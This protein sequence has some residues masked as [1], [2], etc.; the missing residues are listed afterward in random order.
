MKKLYLLILT[1]V[2]FQA[3]TA[4]G[5]TN[6]FNPTDPDVVFTSTN[7]PPAPA[8]GPIAKWGHTQRMNWTTTSF[9]SY[10]YKGMVF[11]LKFPK[12]Y[13]HNT[14]DGKKY[15]ISLFFHG[16]GERGD[17]Y[18]NE[19]SMY[20]GG[21]EWRDNVDNNKFDGFVLYHQSENG[22]HSYYFQRLVELIDSL[23]KH[24]KVDIDRVFLH[25]L[26]SGGQGVFDFLAAYPK[27]ISHTAPLCAAQTE[28]VPDQIKYIHIPIWGFF[29]GKDTNPTLSNAEYVVGEFKNKGGNIKMTVYPEQGHG[30]WYSAWADPG[31][32][33]FMNAGHK[34]NPLVFFGRTE[35]C[36][37]DA[38]SV[39]MGLTSGFNAYEWQKDGVNIAGATS[40]QITVTQLGT[41]RV[42]FKRTATS[43][44]S[45]YSPTPV[46]VKYKA[47][48]QTPAIQITGLKSK[49]LPSPDGSTTTPLEIPGGYASYEW[50]RVS[51]NVVVSTQS[52]YNAAPGQYKAKV[53]EQ[54]GCS[55]EFSPVFT[56]I[57][58][59]GANA[60]DAAKNLVAIANSKT[61]IQLDWSDNPNAPNNE[62]G[63]EIY[64]STTAGGPYS[65]IMINPA[66][67]LSFLDQGLLSNN[68]YSYIVR[69]VNSNGAAVNS[70]E[71]T[72]ATNVDDSPPSAPSNLRFVGASPSSVSLQWDASIDDI[73]IS[74]YDIYI[75]GQKAYT[76]DKSPFTANNLTNRQTYNFTVRA[77]DL[78]GNLSALSN[79]VTATAKISGLSYKYYE[80]A[81]NALP[82]F[83]ALTPVKTGNSVNVDISVRNRSDNF[84][85]LWQGFIIIPASA[86]YTFETTSDDGSKLYIGPYNHTSTAL[87]NNDGLHGSQFRT[88]TIT[89]QAGVYPISITYFEQGGGEAM[90]VWWSSVAAGIPRQ[91]IPNSAFTETVS[92]PE[93]APIAPS[94]LQATTVS[95]DKIN[96]QWTD[97]SS[98][99]T[100]FEIVRS[101][102]AGG[103]FSTITTVGSNIQTFTDNTGIQAQTRYF[104]KVRAIGAYG[105]SVYSSNYLNASFKLNNDYTDFSGNGRTLSGSINPPSFSAA[106][107]QEG[108]HSLLFDGVNDYRDIG[109]GT[110]NFT[111]EL[112]TARTVSLWMKSELNTG[113]RLIFEL[114]GSDNGLALRLNGVNLEVGIA[115]NNSRSTISALFNSLAWKHVTVTY[116]ANA[117]FLYVDGVQVASKTNLTFTQV[118]ASSSSSRLATQ[119]GTNAFNANPTGFFKGYM[120]DLSYFTSALSP[121]DVE[122]LKNGTFVTSSAVTAN[123]P[124]IPVDPTSL[125]ASAASSNLNN[126]VWSDNSDNESGF[127]IY[128]SVNNNNN[129]RL[130]A[131]VPGS[132]GGSVNYADSSLFANVLYYYKVRAIGL[133][134]NSG[135]SN[136]SQ[137]KTSNG[138]PVLAPIASFTMKYGTQVNVSVY[139]ED[140]DGDPITLA[141]TNLPAFA[142]FTDNGNGT[143]SLVFSPAIAN[144]GNYPNIT[145]TATDANSGTSNSTFTVIVNNNNP[146][147]LNAIANSTIDEGSTAVINLSASDQDGNTGLT[148]SGAN[149]PAFV[150]LAGNANGT[151]QVTLNP[152][153]ASSG[154]YTVQITVQDPQ[155]GSATRP[156][157]ITVNDKNPNTR[158]LVNL[159]Y[160]STGP[161]PWNNM[162][163]SSIANLKNTDN[164]STTV[165]VQFSTPGWWQPW[166]LGATTGNNSGVYPD[167]V[168]RD[169]YYFGIYGGPE[170]VNATVSG[171]T[172]GKVYNFKFFASSTWTGFPDNGT[173]IYTIGS[174]SASLAVQNNTQNTANISGVMPDG[175][176]KIVFTMSK[177]PGTPLGYLNA[178][179]FET[180]FDDGSA[181]AAPKDLKATLLQGT[182]VKLTW[183][184]VAFNETRYNVY[185]STDSLGT[186]DLLNPAATNPNDSS[187]N[188]NT[189]GALTKYYYKVKAFNTNGDSEFSTIAGITTSNNNPQVSTIQDVVV[190]TQN[191][192]NVPFTATDNPGDVVIVTASLPSFATLQNVG[193]GNYNIVLAPSNGDI[194]VFNASVTATDSYGGTATDHFQI[195]VN[196][197]NTSSIFINFGP[198]GATAPLPW[199]NSL[200]YTFAGRVVPNLKDDAGNNS[201]VSLTY[202][203]GWSGSLDYGFNTGNNSG[204]Y[205]D[206]VL[207]SSLYEASVTAKRMQLSG[208]DPSKLYNIVALGSVNAG[209]DASSTYTVGL[210]SVVLNASFNSTK[211]VQ[212][213]GIS[214]DPGGKIILNITK[215]ASST[216]GYLNAIVIQSYD[217][218][219]SILS[220]KDLFVEPVHN[221]RTTLKLQW[222]DRSAT[223][224]SM[225]VW[226]STSLN[227]SYTL[228]ATL[229]AN[230]TSHT[231]VG[232]NVNTRYFYKISAVN[233]ATQSEFSNVGSATTPNTTVLINLTWRYPAG[234]PWNNTA[235]NPQLGDRFAN[236]FDDQNNNTGMALNLLG[237]FNGEFY[238][239]MN[240]GNNSGIFPDQVLIGSYWID[241]GQ[242]SPLKLDGLDQTKKYRVGFL[243]STDWTGELTSTLTINGKTVYLN[244][245]KN[246]SKVVYINDISPNGDGEILMSF[247]A[248]GTYGHLG[249][250]V[251]QSYTP[252]TDNGGAAPQTP[253]RVVQNVQVTQELNKNTA[254]D[255]SG[256]EK[257]QNLKAF[258]NP[259]EDK[260]NI[261]FDKVISAK[262]LTVEV[263]S[264]AG[265]ALYRNEY[266]V[267]AGLGIVTVKIPGNSLQPG[268]YLARISENGRL[269]REFKLVKIK[270]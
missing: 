17:L 122:A 130:L 80:G 270:K 159:V 137:S 72:T 60:P 90:Q 56:V 237:Y 124:A 50:R 230:S 240:T 49:V 15:P 239:G 185:R 55:A 155:G 206:A 101:T 189:T 3:F 227:G 131:S 269:A 84:A 62:T 253:N 31:F 220:P 194:G 150:T 1:I 37:G 67:S 264:L 177:A 246:I 43:T 12:T 172:P 267:A 245:H 197:R 214:P 88:G 41:Y 217:A 222:A 228:E 34:A 61:S 173:T 190:K 186:Y 152:G 248:T 175:T 165:G 202:V 149:F 234:L 195:L 139:A 89:L 193:G 93:A 82:D 263:F 252:Y 113:T 104:Y 221:S 39:K 144:Q 73:G 156:F 146:P 11:R 74:K 6:P 105:E 268:L 250:L 85:I 180:I 114:G 145:V 265:Q 219:A 83:N 29:G 116:N 241:N 94:G 106:D 120:D 52:T 242:I 30:I 191:T 153:Y 112:H 229:P 66:N 100:G 97:N 10:Y 91:Q 110:G 254:N 192:V 117:V 236:L 65:L 233:G 128:R 115:S 8:Y 211:S 118:N 79:Q 123:L 33:P 64:R 54:Y 141:V 46:V 205:P 207:K 92:L 203:D 224:A 77:R 244:S 258:P 181:P 142:S 213:N 57:S 143:A 266:S 21:K 103:V 208:L 161:T 158:F 68:S 176:G 126:L 102:T 35:Y 47:V 5:Q 216:Y 119:N 170:T 26:S 215:N 44:W 71:A 7:R 121:A 174:K 86:S 18:D 23:S 133:G 154:A 99:E 125:V 134:G 196:D 87:V 204:I 42:R 188:D 24:V 198:D 179:E 160:N 81:W 251:I 162:T 232:L 184:D 4:N 53:T 16:L 27:T 140:N 209:F 48:T 127:E 108:S 19:W 199:N 262:K 210:Q 13:Q 256:K 231:S 36:V 257:L 9:K 138:N 132:T 163:A 164:Q 249:A 200:G 59:N 32:V 76:T 2:A 51:D 157:T 78:A 111:R 40:N 148:W 212:L 178:F 169:Y 151:A 259:F 238:G 58:S 129:Y 135:Y 109:G 63:F 167:A 260:F 136:E 69:S 166:N 75:D 171:L 45:E 187:Y 107:K 225:Q 255:G 218:S 226:R 28:D 243:G 20:H 70:N 168:M 247:S 147:T 14:A 98:N 96:L 261:T 38:I 22:Y 182:G 95:F 223:E 201:G 235:T 25:G 183:L